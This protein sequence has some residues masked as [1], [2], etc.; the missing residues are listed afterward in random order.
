MK[1]RAYK[2]YNPNTCKV[3][4]S[5]DIMFR[6]DA[7]WDWNDTANTSSLY[8]LDDVFSIESSLDSS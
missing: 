5:R 2:M 4:L 7:Q 6:E 8:M 1:T 3:L